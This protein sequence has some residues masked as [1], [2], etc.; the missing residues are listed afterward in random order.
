MFHDFRPTVVQFC[1]IIDMNRI[2]KSVNDVRIMH[3]RHSELSEGLTNN[4]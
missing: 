4:F 3:Y 1:L 2:D